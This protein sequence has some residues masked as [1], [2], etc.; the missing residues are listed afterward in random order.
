MLVQIYITVDAKNPE[1]IGRFMEACDHAHVKPVILDLQIAGESRRDWL[2]SENFDAG[3]PC[4]IT[5]PNIV[6]RIEGTCSMLRAAGL[7]VIRRKVG[8]KPGDAYMLWYAS[9]LY[10]ECHLTV[11]SANASDCIKAVQ[12]AVVHTPVTRDWYLSKRTGVNAQM[13]TFRCF[14]KSA[15]LKLHGNTAGELEVI[16]FDMRVGTIRSA[17]MKAGLSV[18]SKTEDC[19]YDDN[20]QHDK[21]WINAAQTLV[22]QAEEK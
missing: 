7:K 6:N 16:R 19:I 21:D 10:R 4:A 9:P 13:F 18:I 8:V 2:T 3:G 22:A 12:Q 15:P 5:W 11:A 20:I 14:P 17:L 1:D